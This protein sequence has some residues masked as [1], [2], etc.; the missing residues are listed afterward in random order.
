MRRYIVA[1]ALTALLAGCASQQ[2]TSAVGADV[3]AAEVALTAAE[4]IALHYA[5]LPRCPAAVLCSSQA[6]VDK[7]K[8]LDRTAYSAVEAAKANAGLLAVAI[9]AIADLRHAIPGA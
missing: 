8:A 7:I 3:A 2:T 1:G 4:T 6:V 5:T 9:T